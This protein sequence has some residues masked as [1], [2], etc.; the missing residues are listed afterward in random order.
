MIT[1]TRTATAYVALGSNMGDRLG[2]MRAAVAALDERSHTR[3]DFVSGVASL[4]ES[5]AVVPASH[6][7]GQPPYL[8]SVVRLQTTL[9]PRDVLRTA[10]QI[11]KSLGR[12]RRER[13]GARIIDIDLLFYDELVLRDIDLTLPHPRLQ[14]R[15]FVLYPLAEISGD[16]R[17]P[18]LDTT[19]PCLAWE[20]V[21]AG[22]TAELTRVAGPEWV[23]AR[24]LLGSVVMPGPIPADAVPPRDSRGDARSSV[25]TGPVISGVAATARW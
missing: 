21:G 10:L 1:V 25:A 8:N 11:E 4:Y 19:I 15:R 18:T 3:V 20:L 17:H 5:A 16:L 13:W 7:H 2:A 9:S 22:G 6:Q 23:Y 24:P 14:E 12:I